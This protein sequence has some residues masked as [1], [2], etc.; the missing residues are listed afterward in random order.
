MAGGTLGILDEIQVLVSDKLQVV[1]YKW[2]SRNFSVSSNDAK[3]L[4]QKFIQEH[5]SGI[6]VI[7]T[8][9]G[10]LRNNPEIYRVKLVSGLKL[11]EAK[12]EFE[13]NFSVQVY[14]VQA[15]IPEDPA[16]VWNAEFVQAEQLFNQPSNVENCLRDNRFCGV[17]NAFVSRSILGKSLSS[18]QP[19]SGNL[20]TTPKSTAL[21]QVSSVPL[22]REERA[23][24]ASSKDLRPASAKSEEGKLGKNTSE[25]NVQ[26]GK[27]GTAKEGKSDLAN[28][29]KNQNEKGSSSGGSLA[30]L[31]SRASAKPKSNFLSTE[32][33][34]GAPDPAASAEAQIHASEAVDSLSS[35]DEGHNLKHRRD[36]NGENNRKRRVVF[37]FSDEEEEDY[38]NAVSLSSQEPP[39]SKS[40]TDSEKNLLVEEK[41]LNLEEREGENLVMKQEETS[42]STT[43]V[44][45]EKNL[46]GS[47][48]TKTCGITLIKKPSSLLSEALNDKTEK[49]KVTN[50]LSTSPKRRK[51]LKTRVDERGREVTEV[52]WEGEAEDVNN[53]EK[54]A[55]TDNAVKKEPNNS[56][57]PS[58]TNKV[59]PPTAASS[60]VG[61]KAGN[62]KTG[63]GVKDAKQGN[64]LSFFKKI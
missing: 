50:T 13:D 11:A 54:K 46:E 6:E 19:K 23:I 8:L 55:V 22:P 30:N 25:D 28:N 18:S 9:S 42:V 17:Y 59:L 40:T 15:C 26:P 31:W 48:K 49:D 37:D 51:V 63:K 53:S 12:Q 27:S 58:T 3:R 21:P 24:E 39:K 4:L 5:G 43:I 44:L 10:W 38:A 7:Y 45:P 16:T 52:V 35:D 33:T 1:S 34:N 2:L 41:D 60:N 14:S 20:G 57:K 29:K 61:S 47:S 36:S 32:I 56:V 64:I 62:K